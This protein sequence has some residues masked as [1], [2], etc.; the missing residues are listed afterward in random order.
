[1]ADINNVTLTGRITKDLEL[2]QSQ[3]GKSYCKFSIAVNGMKKDETDILNCIAWEKTAEILCQ[4]SAKGS[5]IGVTGRIK[6]G[7]YDNKGKKVYTTDI[8]VNSITLLG[9]KKEEKSNSN[10][11]TPDNYPF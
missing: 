9:S 8:I 6:T 10:T 5:Q 2:Q 4:Y 11:E 3:A 7:S 1:M